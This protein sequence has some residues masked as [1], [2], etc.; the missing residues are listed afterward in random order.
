MDCHRIE[1]GFERSAISSVN[2]LFKALISF[3]VLTV[4][5]KPAGKSFKRI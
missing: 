2:L 3:S 4:N 1:F 5:R